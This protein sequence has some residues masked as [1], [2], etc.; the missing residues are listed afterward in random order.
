MA[1]VGDSSSPGP[2]KFNNKTRKL[3]GFIVFDVCETC[4]LILC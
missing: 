3:A 1:G 2:T 4:L